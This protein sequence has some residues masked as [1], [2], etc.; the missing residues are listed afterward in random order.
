M[1]LPGFLDG[2]GGGELTTVQA[3]GFASITILV[4]GAFLF[5]QVTRYSY[6][7]IQPT[8]NK[9]SLSFGHTSKVHG[10]AHQVVN[11]GEVLKRSVV[12]VFF[13]LPIVLLAHNLGYVVDYGIEQMQLPVSLSGILIA[14][15]VFT[16]ES[17]AAIK[18]ILNNEVQRA[19]NLCHGAFVSTVGL[20]FPAVLIIGLIMDK[21]VILGLSP[22]EIILFSITLLLSFFCFS[23]KRTSPIFGVLHLAVFA[24]YLLLVFNS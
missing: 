8:G 19:I 18:A 3:I 15:I 9:M 7:Y 24:I 16:P 20:T 2:K 23:G 12:L 21:Q 11:K 5:Y 22:T 6:L 14:I 10:E 13:I 1:I 17:A 4:Y